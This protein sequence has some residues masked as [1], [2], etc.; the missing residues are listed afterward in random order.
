MINLGF[1]MSSTSKFHCFYRFLI[2]FP[3]APLNRPPV[4]PVATKV[5]LGQGLRQ[6]LGGLRLAGSRRPCWRSTKEHAQGL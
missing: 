5:L 1:Q 3:R 2:G 6:I 4:S